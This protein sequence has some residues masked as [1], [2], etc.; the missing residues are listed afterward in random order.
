MTLYEFNQLNQ[1][2]QYDEVLNKSGIYLDNYI[3]GIHRFNLYAIDRFFVELEYN[4]K[5]NKIV[6]LI[7]FK[8]G[9]TLDKYSNLNGIF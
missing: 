6:N 1:Q 3:N 8:Q 7:A 9:K 4:S 2:K 5:E